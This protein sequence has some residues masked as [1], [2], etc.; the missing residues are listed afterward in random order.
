MSL[1]E[2]LGDAASR[3]VQSFPATND[4]ESR[5]M[6]DPK[7]PLPLLKSVPPKRP[8]LDIG[9]GLGSAGIGVTLTQIFYILDRFHRSGR[10]LAQSLR[11]ARGKYNGIAR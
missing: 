10:Y 9:Q 8:S 2:L 4:I 11:H 3:K 1:R 6:P 5:F 7:D